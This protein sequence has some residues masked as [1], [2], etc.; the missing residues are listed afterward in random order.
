M[1]HR[2]SS[3]LLLLLKMMALLLLLRTH[4]VYAWLLGPK[5]ED[6]EETVKA[7][8]DTESNCLSISRG[9]AQ[10]LQLKLQKTLFPTP[11]YHANKISQIVP[12]DHYHQIHYPGTR[13]TSKRSSGTRTKRTDHWIWQID[14]PRTRLLSRLFWLVLRLTRY[15]LMVVGHPK[16][17]LIRFTGCP[18]IYKPTSHYSRAR[19]LR[20]STPAYP[21]D[22]LSRSMMGILELV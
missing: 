17:S 21:L 18:E 14:G 12:K 9:L 1:S 13:A 22:S 16:Q 2:P 19:I 4:I 11:I 6:G 20:L 3:L 8:F 15:S 10:E 7:L 5:Q